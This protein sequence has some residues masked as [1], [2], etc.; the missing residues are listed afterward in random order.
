M[1][2]HLRKCNTVR[3]AAHTLRHAQTH[4]RA[5]TAARK[6][7][8]LS[9]VRRR[10]LP[11]T[12]GRLR[13]RRAVRRRRADRK[14]CR[15]CEPRTPTSRSRQARHMPIALITGTVRVVARRMHHPEHPDA[16]ALAAQVVDTC[17]VRLP[18][19]LPCALPIGECRRR[20]NHH[21]SNQRRRDGYRFQ[22]HDFPLM[23]G[24]TSLHPPRSLRVARRA[25]PRIAHEG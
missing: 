17:L 20:W 5:A 6:L 15:A 22:P 19:G 4:C 12:R 1:V 13:R 24:P 11:T 10:K 9:G 23:L 16:A 7:P 3:C 21:P 2:A 18:V 8:R 14:R 25:G